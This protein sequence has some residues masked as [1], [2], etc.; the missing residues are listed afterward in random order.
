MATKK[1]KLG[2]VGC[3]AMGG[4]HKQA[5]DLVDDVIE[6]AATCDIDAG[7]AK[8]A[9]DALGAKHHSTDYRDIFPFCDALMLV[10]PHDLHF[11]VGMECLEANKHVLMEKPLCNTEQQ[12]VDLIRLA[13]SKKLVLMT[14]YCMRFHP[15]SVKLKELIDS[16]AYGEV[17]Q[18]SIW[19]EQYT[20]PEEGHWSLSAERL[21]GGQFFSH[22]CHYVDLLV[23][24]LGN[25]L[26]G[27]H[28][29]SNHC[30]PW[31]EKEG[32][33]NMVME[34]ESGAM[35]YHFGTWGAAGSKLGYSIHTHF[36]KAMA[37]LNYGEGYLKLL[38]WGREPETVLEYSGLKHTNF[39]IRSFAE[40]IQ[41]GTEPLT[42]GYDSLQGL[43]VI[44]R[45][46]EAEQK[47]TMAD[48]R[49]LGH[50]RP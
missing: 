22:G 35:G 16:K 39:E 48:L 1:V 17:F 41:N 30:V 26:R 13:D 27:T 12:C 19:T 15:L 33:S 11:G 40:C 45:M 34:F 49:G 5:F 32:T 14:A 2:I 10:L 38:R 21:G 29:G 28:I 20:R 37:E 9:A 44:W 36:E 3:G 47:G 7:R 43:R 31:M 8:E 23:W 6:V 46:Y 50:G 42:N 18:M 24:Y 25:P 4:T